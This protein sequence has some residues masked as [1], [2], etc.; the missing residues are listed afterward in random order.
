MF[1]QSGDIIA[2][3]ENVGFQIN[4]VKDVTLTKEVA[5][6]IYSGKEGEPF[7]DDLV[8]HMTEGTCKVKHS[9]MI[10]LLFYLIHFNKL[11][12]DHNFQ[13]LGGGFI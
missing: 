1:F 8:N 12:E 5:S 4:E 10:S 13:F 7:F 2:Q 3:L 11:G 9:Y 6:K